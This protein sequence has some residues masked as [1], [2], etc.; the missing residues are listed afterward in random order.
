MANIFEKQMQ[1]QKSDMDA[2]KSENNAFKDMEN[3]L[4]SIGRSIQDIELCIKG[5]IVNKEEVFEE[6]RNLIK[7]NSGDVSSD[8]ALIGKGFSIVKTSGISDMKVR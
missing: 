8:F 6:L 5:K 2:W 4:S 1:K 7:Y 3:A